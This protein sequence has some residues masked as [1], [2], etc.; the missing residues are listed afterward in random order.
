M[1]IESTIEVGAPAST[2]WATLGER[3]MHFADWAAPIVAS[4]AASPEP[5]A[6]GALRVCELRGFGPIKP[7][8]LTER[9]VTFDS[10]NLTLR[11]DVIEGLPKFVSHS[12]TAWSVEALSAERSLVRVRAELTLHGPLSLAASLLR[13]QLRKSGTEVLE[14][15]QH[16]VERGEPHPRKRKAVREKRPLSESSVT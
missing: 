11:Y 5:L 12:R 4:R 13:G 3:F 1:D 8:T 6:C 7:G 14:E 9:L 15:L 2:L 16:W 10:A